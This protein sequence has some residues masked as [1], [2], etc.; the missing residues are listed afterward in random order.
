M[1]DTFIDDAYNQGE[2]ILRLAPCFV[3]RLFCQ[4]GHRLKLHPNDYYALGMARGAIK[5]RWFSSVIAA[6]NGPLAPPDEGMSYVA[7][8]NNG[9]DKFLFREAIEQLGEKLIGAE[10]MEKYGTWP[11][12]SKFFDY[13]VP[14]FHHVHLTFEKAKLVG[15]LGKP[16]CYYYP[17][18]YN[19]YPGTMPVTY[20]GFSPEVTP[21]EVKERLKVYEQEDNRITEL[22]RAYRIELGTGWYTPAGVVHAPGSYLTYE[23]Q[24]NSDV[25]S[26]Y[27]NVASGEVYVK[28]FLNEHCPEDKKDDVDYIFSFLDW[29]KNVDPDY[30][31]H[32]FRPPLMIEDVPD[33]CVEKW[34]VYANDYVAAKELTVLPGQSVIIRD[35]AAYGVILTQGHGQLGVHNCETPTL[36]EFGQLSNDEFF[37][38]EMAARQGVRITNAS[39]VEPLVMLKHFGPNNR[40]APRTVQ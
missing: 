21:A 27:E 13:S 9:K 16:E 24:W 7:P 22:S 14:L 28:N 1:T 20:F 32:Y 3:P 19:N 29:E 38:S 40:Q 17:P 8:T 35:D 5:E 34:I 25:N 15:R 39:D 12:Y 30:K 36:L 26:V 6:S 33:G 18:Q 11:M 37:V 23:P 10:L 31:K 2:G 4:P